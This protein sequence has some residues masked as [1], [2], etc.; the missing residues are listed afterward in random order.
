M[1]EPAD[2][3]SNPSESVTG[4]ART[5]ANTLASKVLMVQF[6][7]VGAVGAAVDTAV[8]LFL[9]EQFGVLEEIATLVG[10]EISIVVM[11]V[12]NENWT[13]AEY[14]KAGYRHLFARL[15]RSHL[16]RSGAVLIQFV[17]FVV[18]YRFLS[19]Q[20]TLAGIDLWL[21]GAKLA[22]IGLGLIVNYV[23]ESFY[24]WELE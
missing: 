23:F 12:L 22:G 14:G 5:M 7:S 2:E 11:F 17:T 16:V 8:L 15:A 9:V 20:V 21:V 10:I 6:L 19:V 13:Y 4:R 18:L 1:T 24:T 3:K